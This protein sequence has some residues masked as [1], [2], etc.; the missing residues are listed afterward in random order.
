[1]VLSD[2]AK[3]FVIARE[4]VKVRDLKPHLVE[5]IVFF[6]IFQKVFFAIIPDF[7]IIKG[8]VV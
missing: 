4:I 8:L 6:L 5:G 3:K 7:D 2:N 1:M